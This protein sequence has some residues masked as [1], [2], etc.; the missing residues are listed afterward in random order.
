MAHP[1]RQYSRAFSP[2]RGEGRP[3]TISR[4]PVGFWSQV[5]AKAKREGVS[6]RAL[7]LE[8][9]QRW[10]DEEPKLEGGPDAS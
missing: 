4:I 9:L 5:Q 7:I 2:S 3:F 8:F 6:L 10:L 1:T